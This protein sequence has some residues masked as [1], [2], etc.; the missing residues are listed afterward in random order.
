MQ[1]KKKKSKEIQRKKQGKEDQGLA[2]PS[3]KL[4]SPRGIGPADGPTLRSEFAP[5]SA[6]VAG[7]RAHQ[8]VALAPLRL[9]GE[10]CG[11]RGQLQAQ[12]EDI[13]IYHP[14]QKHYSEKN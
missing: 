10:G 1:K 12:Q 11:N 4:S 7:S 14:F 9:E 2:P 6:C 13:I 3:S 8:P 5:D